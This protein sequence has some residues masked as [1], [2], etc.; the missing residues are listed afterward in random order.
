MS[1]CMYLEKCPIFA[2]FQNE[3]IKNIWIGNY[4]KSTPDK[5]ERKKLRDSGESAPSTMLPNGKHLKALED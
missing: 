4:C 3:G 1:D 5:C 2:K